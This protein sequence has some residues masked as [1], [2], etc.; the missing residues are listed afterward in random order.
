MSG[1]GIGH[2]DLEAKIVNGSVMTDLKNW[3]WLEIAKYNRIWYYFQAGPEGSPVT[4]YRQ[5]ELIGRDSESK[6]VSDSEGSQG[7]LKSGGKTR[8]CSLYTWI[9]DSRNGS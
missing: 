3:L 4:T 6:H 1:R 5:S 9:Y 7:K 8:K 2:K